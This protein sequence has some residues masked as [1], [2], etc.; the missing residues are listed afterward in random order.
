MPPRKKRPVLYE[1]VNRSRRSRG[2]TSTFRTP[3][4]PPAPPGEPAPPPSAAPPP[5]LEPLP[6]STR[7]GVTPPTA[8][9]IVHLAGRRILLNLGWPELLFL[10]VLFIAIVGG[11]FKAGQRSAAPPDPDRSAT[12]LDEPRATPLAAVPA[13]GLPDS[14]SPAP[15]ESSPPAGTTPRTAPTRP[16]PEPPPPAL[17]TGYHYVVVQFFPKSRRHH[18]DAARDFLRANAVDC[19]VHSAPND[20][21]LVVTQRFDEPAAAR[22][23]IRR[24]RELGQ[25]YTRQGGGYD[26]AGC[27]TI[28]F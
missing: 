17:E 10:S 11:A 18:A 20:L 19:I 28:R 15:A 16:P 25:E 12:F 3:V 22:D 5:R 2:R 21:R 8:R 6:V 7:A 24:L 4:A 23:L 9:P 14:F 13:D 1:V 26:F 27:Q